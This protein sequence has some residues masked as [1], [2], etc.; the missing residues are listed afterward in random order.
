LPFSAER[1]SGPGPD[2]RSI[3]CHRCGTTSHNQ[4]DVR[5][6]WCARCKRSHNEDNGGRAI[7]TIYDHPRD[8]PDCFVA[9]KFLHDQPTPEVITAK[10]LGKLRDE[11]RRRGLVCLARALGDNS[12]IVETLL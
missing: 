3:T 1:L 11:I 7:W 9:R 5:E 8:F 2:G 4:I 10:T 6:R 12:K